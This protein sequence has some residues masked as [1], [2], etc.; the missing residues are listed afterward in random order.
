VTIDARTV[1]IARHVRI[2][3]VVSECGIKLRGRIER[4]GP[5]PKCGGTDR[6]SVNLKK[7]C[8][9]CRH[10]KPKKINGDVIGL[11]QFLH[12]VDFRTAISILAGE[13]PGRGIERSAPAAERRRSNGAP[14]FWCHQRPVPA[15]YCGR[16]R[17]TAGPALYKWRALA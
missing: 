4:V 5:C 9:N 7:Q 6:F 13:T 14:T 16:A 12:G 8:W 10:C 17:R 15:W 2:E 1:E 3:C 11:V